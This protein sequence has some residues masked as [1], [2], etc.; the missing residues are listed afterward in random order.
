MTSN[1]YHDRFH[2]REI[3]ASKD[4]DRISFFFLPLY[5]FNLLRNP[6]LIKGRKKGPYPKREVRLV[7]IKKF[8]HAIRFG[9]LSISDKVALPI[10]FEKK[11]HEITV[12]N[13][14][15]LHYRNTYKGKK[16]LY[17]L[18]IKK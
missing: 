18:F 9:L 11:K 16:I 3:C 2:F 7:S 1:V 5:R 17:H 6:F 10:S 8:Q 15:A 14:R 4:P 12:I 13:S